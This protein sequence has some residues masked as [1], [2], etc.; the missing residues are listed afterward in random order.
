M[1]QIEPRFLII[2][3]AIEE[4]LVLQ[5]NK[6]SPRNLLNEAIYIDMKLQ[7]L[8]DLKEKEEKSE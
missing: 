4:L 6:G 1:N 7:E 2:Q 3:K 5:A 8:D